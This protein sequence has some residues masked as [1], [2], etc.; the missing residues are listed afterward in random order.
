M[1]GNLL[2]IL[3]E[4]L[5]QDLTQ[6]RERLLT[7]SDLPTVA[8]LDEY[9]AAFRRRFGPDVLANLDGEALLITMHSH[10]NHDSLV[11]WLEFK[12]DDEF[13]ANFGS[14]AGGSALK[15]GI[16]RRHATGMWM[17][18]SP[19]NQQELTMAEA[20]EVARRHRDQLLKGV[21]LLDQLPAAGN[22]ADYRHLQEQLDK[23]A[24]DVSQ[25]AWGH[26]YFS[27]LFPDK[28]DDYHNADY[29]RYHLIK[30]LQTPPTGE[31]R[32][33]VAGRFVATAAE[34][35][36]PINHLT[37]VLNSRDGNPHGYWRISTTRSGDGSRWPM[38]RDTNCVAIGWPELGDLSDIKPNQESKEKIREALTTRYPAAALVVSRQTREIFNFLTRIIESEFVL[39]SEGNRILGIGRVAGDYYFEAGSDMPHRLPVEWLSLEE[40]TPPASEGLQT[41]VFQIKKYE[42]QVEVE[43]KIWGA[44]PIPVTPSIFEPVVTTHKPRPVRLEGIPGRI[45]AILERKRQV[46]LYGPPGT[47]KTYL[48]GQAARDLAALAHFDRVFTQLDSAEQA[49]ITGQN[50][51]DGRVRLVAFHP[52]YG[53]EDF[54]EG[55]RPHA[56][57]GQLLFE[58]R[59]GTFK[60][61]CL[62]AAAN[63]AAHFYLIIDEI[64]RGDIPRIFGELLTVLEKDKRSQAIILPLTGQPFQV[65]DNVYL[66][67]TMNTADRSIALLDAALRRRF[68]FI[69]LMPDARLLQDAV[70]DSIPL[71]PWLEALNARIRSHLGRDARNRQIGHAYLFDQGRP[72]ISFSKLARAMQDDI[73]PLLEEYCY[74]DYATLAH[75]LGLALVDVGQ[76][77]FRHELFE[78][79]R[80][81][82]LIQALKAI[83]P[84]LDTSP[85]AIA[86]E[87][88]AITE[89]ISDA[90]PDG[91]ESDAATAP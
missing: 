47:G 71:G 12:N 53:Y 52:A 23:L 3:T 67:G 4:K 35:G 91:G 38:M 6:W 25:K 56:Q 80:K 44:V 59:D 85:A 45:Q 75:I 46:I 57:Q 11:Y 43:R 18:G 48:A 28:L 15:F 51:G 60:E 73:L 87:A 39:P 84:N 81:A 74:E 76:Q 13:P 19:Q 72:L 27:L 20:I 42:N 78:P 2:M 32:Y 79:N 88:Q 37:S 26:K 24:P 49:V 1:Q 31:G 65:P 10:G 69:E 41:T 82:D 22:D 83:D 64:N 5:I 34:L 89:A 29:Q 9:Y 33:L 30:L 16:Y 40:W 50:G 90:D 58:P 54:M 14:I 63:P 17:T 70:V 61:L 8:Q 66:I 68:G 62:T 36:W 86:A 55:Y 21:E 7:E 77:R